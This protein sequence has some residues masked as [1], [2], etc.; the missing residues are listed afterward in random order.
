MTSLYTITEKSLTCIVTLKLE[1]HKK[2]YRLARCEGTSCAGI[3][4]HAKT[5]SGKTISLC[6]RGKED[7]PIMTVSTADT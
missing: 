7:A 3:H 4:G 1:F 6:V 5:R 2:L